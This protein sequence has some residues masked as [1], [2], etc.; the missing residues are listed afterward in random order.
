ML[1][2]PYREILREAFAMGSEK[3][4]DDSRRLRPG[5]R[6][7]PWTVR[8]D[9]GLLHGADGSRHLEPKQMDLLLFLTVRAPEVVSKDDIFAAVWPGSFVAEVGLKRNI[10][11][12]RRAL[13]DDARDPRFIKTIPKRGYRMLLTPEPL[14]TRVAPADPAPDGAT[15]TG[16]A[17]DAGIG[18]TRRPA[19]ERPSVA[20]LPF[21]DI[22]SER[23]QEY[24]CDGITEQIISTL[25]HAEGL[26]VAARTSSFAFKNRAADVRRIGGELNVRAVLEGSVRKHGDRL[27]INARLI[28]V[29]DGYNLWSS[30]FDRSVEDIFGIQ[31]QIAQ[32]ITDALSVEL[33]ES[34]RRTIEK[35]PTRDVEAYDFYLRGRQLFYRSKRRSIKNAVEMFERAARHDPGYA[36]AWAGI[37]DCHAY[38]YMY[39]GGNPADLARA[40]EASGKALGLDPELAEVHSSRGLS[41]ALA[42][43]WVEAEQQFKSAIALDPNLFEAHYF[44][45]RT[46]FVQGK[47]AKAVQLY[48]RA[49]EIEPDDFQASSLEAFTYRAM[50][51]Q[52]KVEEVQRRTLANVE[53]HL[54]SQPGD[55]RALYLGATA[56][57]DLG[58]HDRGI[59]MVQRSLAIDPEDPYIVYGGACFYAQAG[60]FEEALRC[61]ERAVEAGFVHK[62]WIDRDADLDPIRDDPRFRQV[63]ERI[64]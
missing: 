13:G 58:E 4:R 52:D 23:D 55:S 21:A 29:A 14:E 12:L 31:E 64:D 53:R 34:E 17:A 63:I 56:L 28:D 38:L 5:F 44:Y 1:R 20:V 35:T 19:G 24:F 40:D 50:G 45:G 57:L 43:R 26:R 8:P 33:T 61:F 10:S 30:Q 54:R 25:S 3:V 9:R 15:G 36:L 22:S 49:A 59:E 39:F 60:R 48:Q 41:F 47:F 51:R 6:L 27:R 46:C 32:N 16:P 37:S 11:Q 7:G 18:A 2:S 42:K 62:E